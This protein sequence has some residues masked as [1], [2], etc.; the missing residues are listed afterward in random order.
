VLDGKHKHHGFIAAGQWLPI[1]H[2]LPHAQKH[3]KLTEDWLQGKTVIPEIA[4]GG[5]AG[6]IVPLRIEAPKTVKPGAP[7]KL[8]VIADNRKVGHNFPTGPLDVIQAWVEVTV[9]LGDEVVFRSGDLD[10]KGFIRPGAWVL[11]AEGVDRTGTTIDR[12]NLWD[13][14]GVRF[15]R[16]MFPRSSDSQAYTFECACNESNGIENTD[17]EFKA[18]KGD[19]ELVV[20]AVLHYRKVDQALLNVLQPDGTA[21]APVTDMSEASARI[22]IDKTP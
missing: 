21:R 11:K 22:R 3:V 7:V 14:V 6:P 16:V 13:M 2:D 19:G 4:D 9:T 18:P 17:V 8:R 12:H 5:P 1:L 15:K 10:E 20:K